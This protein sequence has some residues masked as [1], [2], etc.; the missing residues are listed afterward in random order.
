ME[1]A[2]RSYDDRL[3]EQGLPLPP[4]GS[5]DDA[6]WIARSGDWWAHTAQGWF[7]FDER[8]KEWKPAPI[9]PP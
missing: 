4:G 3:R 6:R 9:G 2:V 7:W 8:T 5:V 1:D